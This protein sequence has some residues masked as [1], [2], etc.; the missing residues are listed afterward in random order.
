MRFYESSVL[1]VLG[2]NVHAA[3]GGA[4]D[5]DFR[6]ILGGFDEDGLLFYGDDFSDYSADGRDLGFAFEKKLNTVHGISFLFSD[7]L[8]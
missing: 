3:D 8:Y 6:F 2:V 7:I 4:E 5:A 1:S